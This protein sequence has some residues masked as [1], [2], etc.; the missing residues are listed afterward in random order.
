MEIGTF[1]GKRY[2]DSLKR[3]NIDGVLIYQANYDE[4]GHESGEVKYFY[5]NGSPEFIYNAENGT[6]KGEAIRYWNNGDIKEEIKYSPNGEV[7]RTS[8]IIDP[9]K[10]LAKEDKP[11][12]KEAPKMEINENYYTPNGY[13]KIY[14]Q[15]KELWMDGEF[16]NNQ[17]WDGRILI[18]DDEGL[19]LKIEVYKEGV[20]H[21]DGQL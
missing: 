20:Y 3:Y 1:E 15:N 9:V 8:G 18:Y 5:D 13:N 14:N 2:V 21:S 16:K 17:L 19:L 11:E 10:P 7:L 12:S 4:A 6:P